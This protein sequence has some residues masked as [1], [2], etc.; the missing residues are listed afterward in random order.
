MRKSF[1]FDLPDEL[2]ERLG[3]AG[4]RA[5]EAERIALAALAE[6]VDRPDLRARWGFAEQEV[7]NATASG[8]GI[9]SEEEIEQAREEYA[10]AFPEPT[11]PVSP[12]PIPARRSAW[13]TASFVLGLLGFL[14]WFVIF[15]AAGYGQTI[16]DPQKRQMIQTV[17]G[18]SAMLVLMINL[19]ALIS[20]IVGS[21]RKASNGWMAV[22]GIVLNA[23]QIAAL[24]GIVIL[25]L[26]VGAR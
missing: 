15:G 21:T 2:A 23:L 12:S 1:K 5:D 24:V 14:S 11:L 19:G 22:T 6:A 4:I 20:G 10:E 9:I 25:G 16:A 26:T 3:S 7:S 13:A 18:L 8:I 17:A